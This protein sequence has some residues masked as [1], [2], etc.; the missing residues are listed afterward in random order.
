MPV[1]IIRRVLVLA[2]LLIKEQLKE[3]V[4]LFWMIV[5]PAA[6]YY[7]LVYFR[8]CDFTLEVA[9][10]E[11]ASWFYAYIAS[12]VAFFGFSFYIVGR[13]ES[14]FVRS[15]IYTTEAKLIFMLAQFLS[16]SL[17]S[18][19]YC[20]VFYALT[21]FSFDSFDSFD[22]EFL[23]VLARFYLC[24]VLFSILG[25]LLSFLPMSFQNANAVYSILSFVMLV[26]GVLSV[27]GKHSVIGL[28]NIFNPLSIANNVMTGE[29]ED[30][31]ILVGGVLSLFVVVFLLS[32]RFLRINPVWSRY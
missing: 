13:R 27:H 16:Y 9:Y 3:P 1:A 12:S 23:L 6:M 22:S 2:W 18:L 32:L 26:F 29:F 20:S 5:S 24:Y 7:F 10:I 25:L 19:V 31:T 11:R 15:F 17:I 21:Y 14:G 4:A 30:I 28:I 8:G